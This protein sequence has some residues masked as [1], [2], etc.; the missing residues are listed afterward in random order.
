VDIIPTYLGVDSYLF[1]CCLEKASGLV[2]DGLG[3]GHVP[4]SLLPSIDKAV[5]Q[6][7]PVVLTSRVPY[8]RL[9][10]DTYDYAGSETDLLK[11]GAIF[12][13][14]LT[15][16]KARIKLLVLQAAGLT[17]TDIRHELQDTF[18]FSPFFP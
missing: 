17:T 8:G 10:T 12:G 18:Y 4:V 7:I 11:R 13:E 5:A 3:A 6:D 2:L 9:L 15:A 1:D 14:D 16:C